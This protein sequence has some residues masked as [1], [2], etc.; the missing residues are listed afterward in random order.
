MGIEEILLEHNLE[1]IPPARVDLQD[2]V[3]VGRVVNIC[4][5]KVLEKKVFVE[6]YVR[7]TVNYI[8]ENGLN[9]Q[10]M[11]DV[12][13]SCLLEHLDAVE[14]KSF[15]VSDSGIADILVEKLVN[16]NQDGS[17]AYRM[18]QKFL[19]QVC[20]GANKRQTIIFP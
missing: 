4:F 9:Q 1:L 19:V 12:P 14:E 10:V 15:F 18:H 16:F 17:L 3:K 20:I 6:G 13:F 5:L 11:D 2:Q 8:G 7:L